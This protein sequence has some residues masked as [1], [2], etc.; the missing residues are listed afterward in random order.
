V[1]Q[2][3][4][5]SDATRR[6]WLS[7]DYDGNTYMFDA[8]FLTS[9]WTCIFGAG[10]KGIHDV[11]TTDLQHG[12]C[13]FG[14]HFADGP[15]KKRVKA[16]IARLT[17]D[18]WQLSSTAA[19]LG[20]PLFKNDD[21]GWSTRVVDGA[22]VF[23]NRSDFHLGSGCALHVGA[24]E[25]DERPMDWKPEVCW[26]VPVR[27][28]FETDELGHTTYVL[29]EWKRRDWGEGG[30]DFHWWCTEDPEAFVGH[31]RVVE[32]LEGE[33]R[34]L[35]GDPVYDILRAHLD[36]RVTGTTFLPHPAV[37]RAENSG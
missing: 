3:A 28:H 37:R 9:N 19:D 16:A 36:E 35:V 21:G 7:F 14:A 29:R 31:E 12:C 33:I 22:C 26:Q 2:P 11:D 4:P 32:T 24:V 6:D 5:L 15:D 8:S 18:Q 10:C 23:L 20:G 1:S 30:S 25:A 13:S 34:G 27:Y 17:S